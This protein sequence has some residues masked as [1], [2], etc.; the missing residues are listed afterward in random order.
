[1]APDAEGKSLEM[2]RNASGL[3]LHLLKTHDGHTH[4]FVVELKTQPNLYLKAQTSEVPAVSLAQSHAGGC[5][6]GSW[7]PGPDTF[8]KV[9]LMATVHRLLGLYGGKGRREGREEGEVGLKRGK[10]GRAGGQA[11]AA[12]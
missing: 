10:G 3:P 12:T 6:R 9:I 7:L 4:I 8:S 2:S 1:M 11:S 5:E